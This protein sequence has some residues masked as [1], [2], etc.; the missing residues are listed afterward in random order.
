MRTKLSSVDE[1]LEKV[2]GGGG[3][4]MASAVLKALGNFVSTP[5]GRAISVGIPLAIGGSML[6]HGL[7]GGGITEGKRQAETMSYRINRNLNSLTDRIRADEIIGESFGKTVGSESAKQL[8]GLTTDMV[9]KAYDNLKDTMVT[10]P[11][12]SAIF[13]ALKK[14]DPILNEADNKTL[15]EAYHTMS[16]VAPTLA[17]DKNAV[18]SF[19]T[20][21]VVSG[22]G[23]DYNTIKGIADAESSVAN[24]KA[25][26]RR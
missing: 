11:V 25:G 3:G 12:R 18:R 16:K 22:G 23:L 2:A 1:Y 19:L 14:E 6:W 17:T 10:S 15:L 26:P 9:G 4:G 7:G 24:A 20:Q 8:I 13:N 21:A 5:T